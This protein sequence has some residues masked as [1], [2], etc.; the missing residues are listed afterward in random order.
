MIQPLS[1]YKTEEGISFYLIDCGSGLTHLIIFPNGIVM[2][3]DCNLQ[4]ENERESNSKDAILNLMGR[5]IPKKIDDDGNEYQ[6]ID[7]FVNSHRDTDHLKGLKDVNEKFPIQSIW[8]SGYHGKDTEN[9]SDYQYYMELRRRLKAKSKDNL[10]IPTPSKE[11]F[12]SVGDADIYCLCD[13]KDYEDESDELLYESEDKPQHTNC[14]VLLID[15]CGRKMLLTGDSGWDAWQNDI[16]P[17]FSDAELGY[18]DVDIL[19]ASHHGSLSFFG[20]S[21]DADDVDEESLYTDH[22]EAINPKVTLISCGSYNYKNYH[23]PNKT[24]MKIYKEY[25]SNEQVFTTRDYGTICGQITAG[26]EFSCVPL[27]FQNFKNPDRNH[28]VNI[29][30]TATYEG[31]NYRV[32]DGSSARRGS[33]LMFRLTGVGKVLDGNPKI[34]WEVCNSGIG[35]DIEH[36]EI[37]CKGPEEEKSNCNIKQ[38]LK[39]KGTHLIRINVINIEKRFRQQIVFVVKG[40]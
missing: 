5:V 20:S 2:L 16:V 23:L 40:I 30:C 7:I 34:F 14:I 28:F 27:K 36:H 22:I 12:C 25:T 8:D 11:V 38:E 17:N 10:V 32:D 31:E 29:S 21:E 6:P 35:V 1:F 4:D 15:Y 37:Y 19:I 24:T 3:F 9:N 33:D 18:D 26:G 13:S 39:Y